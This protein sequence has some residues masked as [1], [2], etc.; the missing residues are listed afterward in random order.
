MSNNYN[1]FSIKH[2]D[3]LPGKGSIL[4]AEPFMKDAYFQR[5][6]VLLAEHTQEGSMGFIL[7]KKT[8]LYVNDFFPGLEDFPDLPIFLGGPV[9][10]NRLFFIHTFGDDILPGAIPL[11]DQL[12]FD[13]EFRILQEYIKAG[14]PVME[15]VKFFLGYA[16]WTEGQLKKEIENNSWL[17][18]QEMITDKIL[19]ARD[20]T[21]WKQTLEHLGSKYKT[22]AKFPKNP[23]LN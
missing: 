12:Y 8:D 22:W 20:E 10:S 17:V 1:I 23:E 3:I 13:G 21:F 15:H 6:V 2:N 16:G 7:N 18:S 14:Y 5:A 11:T 19:K 4:I 9:S